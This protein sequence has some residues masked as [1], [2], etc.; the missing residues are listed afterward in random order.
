MPTVDAI[1]HFGQTLFSF[2]RDQVL[3][4]RMQDISQI[5]PRFFK[6]FLITGRPGENVGFERR[7]LSGQMQIQ[8]IDTENQC[9]VSFCH[10]AVAVADVGVL[11]KR[12][13]I[14]DGKDPYHRHTDR[15]NLQTDTYTHCF[16]L[17]L[18]IA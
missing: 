10:I 16:T 4:Q 2:R 8:F 9:G 18:P 3:F 15:Q 17:L 6:T 5:D 11:I 12:V 1:L 7:F 14:Q 13:D